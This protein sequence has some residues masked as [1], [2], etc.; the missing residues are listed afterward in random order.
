MIFLRFH[1]VRIIKSPLIE[2]FAERI[3]EK[4]VEKGWYGFW[5]GAGVFGF[6]GV[7]WIR[8][9]S[10]AAKSSGELARA[11]RCGGHRDRTD[12]K[13][14]YRGVTRVPAAPRRG[15]GAWLMTVGKW[16]AGWQDAGG[17]RGEMR[18]NRT[19]EKAREVVEMTCKGFE[20]PRLVKIPSFG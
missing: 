5:N 15:K 2:K 8:S 4:R 14:P 3:R 19:T 16:C 6:W 11:A 10:A 7:G 9:G 18:C 1:S 12:E 20:W 13:P 17:I